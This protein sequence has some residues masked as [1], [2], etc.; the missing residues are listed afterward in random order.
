MQQQPHKA[1][2]IMASNPT[3]TPAIKRPSL[4][5]SS[6]RG[7]S[8]LIALQVGSRALTFIVNQLLL[9]YLNPELLAIS[10]QLEVYS[11]SVLFFSRESLRVAIQRQADTHDVSSSEKSKVPDDHV[12]GSIAAGRT[13]AI[14]NL[15]Y[16]SIYLSPIFA[17]LIALLY[18]GS[19]RSGNSEILAMPYFS[20][21]LKIYGFAAFWEVLSEPCFVVVQQ[22]SRVKI[23]AAAESVATILRCLVTCGWAIRAA[24]NGK[25]VGVLPFAIGQMVYAITLLVVYLYNVWPISSLGGFFLIPKPIYSRYVL[26]HLSKHTLTHPSTPNLYVYDYF[27][28]PLLALSGSLFAQSIFKFLLTQGD[29]ILISSLASPSAQGIYA[30]AANYGGL[31]ARLILQ[32]IEET[33]RNYF[34]KLLSSPSKPLVLKAR[35]NLHTLLRSYVLLSV[36]V[37][38]VGPTLA[39]LLLKIVAGRTWMDSGAGKVLATYCYYIPL[40][41]INGLTEAFVSS[42]ATE[43]EV[44]RQSAWMLAFSAGFGGAAY[45]FL[46][47]LHLGA[48]GLVWANAMNMAI[49][50]LWSTAFISAYLRRHGTKLEFAELLPKATTIAAGVGTFAVL[51]QMEKGFT[52]GLADFI[53]SGVV[54]G[55][56]AMVL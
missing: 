32:P 37:V 14:V 3:P 26:S 12:D 22:K 9:R 10:T 29:T 28:K 8:L 54:A 24:Q 38:A 1:N 6:A 42:V 30:L 21:C 47:V 40:L 5:S 15:A 27:S 7:A 19:L 48:E 13:Q 52:G 34:G 46:K 2:T 25:D 35:T 11:I 44:N 49:R 18:S 51:A 36:A 31:I 50:I 16:V 20:A 39:P 23:R 17:L 41:A 43:A 33:S 4:L 45:L 56:F 55:G 53:K